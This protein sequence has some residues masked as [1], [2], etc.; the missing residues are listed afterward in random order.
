MLVGGLTAWFLSLVA[1]RKSIKKIQQ[2][3]HKNKQFRK[4]VKWTT[5]FSAII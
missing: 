3:K 4:M 2:M 1:A 5:S